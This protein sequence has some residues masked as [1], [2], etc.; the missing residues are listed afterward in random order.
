M[1]THTRTRMILLG[2]LCGSL[3][4]LAQESTVLGPPKVLVIQREFVKP[5]KVG[6]HMKSESAFAKAAAAKKWPGNYLAMY[7]LSG[8][9]RALFMEG[10]PSFEAW[11]KDN[12]QLEKSGMLESMNTSFVADGELLTGTSQAVFTLDEEN[13]LNTG[14]VVHARYFEITQFHVKPG[15]RGEFMQL[16]KMYKDGMAK[17][18]QTANWALYESQFGEKNGGYYLAISAYKSLAEDDASMGDGKKFRDIM[19][20]EGMKKLSA[21]SA[22][23]LE[24]TETNL[25]QFS[26]GMSYPSPEWINADPFWKPKAMSAAAPAKKSATP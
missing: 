20:E 5:G 8:P 21:L 15:H 14:S 24:S 23:C 13:S 25:F 11:E 26:P 4:V 9:D 22:S 18:S 3:P 12:N 6:L 10:Y 16:S 7:S 1:K 2:V 19:G 17:V